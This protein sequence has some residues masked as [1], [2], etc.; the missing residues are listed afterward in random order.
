[1]CSFMVA[2]SYLLFPCLSSHTI[3]GNIDIE[4]DTPVVGNILLF[5]SRV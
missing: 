3:R 4:N 1:M 2:L 5:G